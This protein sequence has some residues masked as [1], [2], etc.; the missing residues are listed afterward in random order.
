MFLLP[1]EICA[2]IVAL[3]GIVG[4]SLY[5]PF[6]SSHSSAER[7]QQL[8]SVNY[9]DVLVAHLVVAA[10]LA[11]PSVLGSRPA[12]SFG[13]SNSPGL[14]PSLA[15]VNRL[16]QAAVLGL[17]PAVLMIIGFQDLLLSRAS[18][19][20]GPKFSVA[21]KMGSPTYTAGVLI[22]VS[23][24]V[25]ISKGK[26]YRIPLHIWFGLF[27]Y[28][29][30][31]AAL[32]TREIAVPVAALTYLL[33]RNHRSRV[34]LAMVPI[35]GLCAISLALN[36]RG[37][38]DGHGLIHYSVLMLDPN[39]YV[40]SASNGLANA[41]NGFHGSGAAMHEGFFG[42]TDGNLLWSLLN[43]F[44]PKGPHNRQSLLDFGTHFPI[45]TLGF[46]RSLGM[47]YVIGFFGSA[48]VIF[49]VL[50]KLSASIQSRSFI[51]LGL[52]L[53][54]TSLPYGL[55]ALFSIFTLQY[56]LH[57]TVVPLKMAVVVG[58]ALF[59][60][61]VMSDT[62]LGIKRAS[63]SRPLP[64]NNFT[65]KPES[66]ICVGTSPD[67]KPDPFF[68]SSRFGHPTTVESS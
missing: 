66:E 55:A 44:E 62:A 20:T 60:L 21:F 42:P 61:R 2:G 47:R 31:G 18:Y 3:Y 1:N 15:T 10:I 28:V 39:I 33:V 7:V 26:C 52:R 57:Q 45:P 35:S 30:V 9:R 53:A 34:T 29:M 64:I 49:Y 68:T 8:D 65:K 16:R 56:K 4:I 6:L 37:A 67:P 38:S 54:A 11:L 12:I 17:L 48:G 22:L 5:G 46:I 24:A 14:P 27:I 13:L 23:C 32:G 59:A 43:P 25:A 36:L 50:G 63:L 51:P 41:L 19:L 58:A 40:A